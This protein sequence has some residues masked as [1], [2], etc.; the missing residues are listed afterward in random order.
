M[1]S[2]RLIPAASQVSPALIRPEKSCLRCTFSLPTLTHFLRRIGLLAKAQSNDPE[3]KR[4]THPVVCNLGKLQKGGNLV[5]ICTSAP[6]LAASR[7]IPGR[8]SCAGKPLPAQRR[9]S[10]DEAGGNV[11]DE[12]GS[13]R[14]WLWWV[15]GDDGENRIRGKVMSSGGK[16]VDS[17]TL[18]RNHVTQAPRK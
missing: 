10:R 4:Q 9:P 2:P 11:S 14:P 3:Y 8:A 18:L 16:A 5:P 15:W 6:P 1:R 7:Q 12:L 17:F 13:L